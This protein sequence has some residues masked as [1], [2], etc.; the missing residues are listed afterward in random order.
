MLGVL[1]PSQHETHDA[2]THRRWSLDV[3]PRRKRAGGD[4]NLAE[5][6]ECKVDVGFGTFRAIPHQKRWHA[7]KALPSSWDAP[8][9]AWAMSW[10]TRLFRLDPPSTD[11]PRRDLPFR[12]V[13]FPFI[14]F[15]LPGLNRSVSRLFGFRCDG[16]IELRFRHGTN[17]RPTDTGS[18]S[19]PLLPIP[20]EDGTL[21][22]RLDRGMDVHVDGTGGAHA[23]RGR[24]GR[25]PSS[26]GKGTAVQVGEELQALAKVPTRQVRRRETRRAPRIE[27]Y[28]LESRRRKQG[29]LADE[30]AGARTKRRRSP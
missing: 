20:S 3:P 25:R 6:A 7:W 17:R 27:S 4:P 10:P 23:V 28:V 21:R 30:S 16:P 26:P 13:V 22:R 11:D 18:T 1:C 19:P 29:M 24:E 8:D 15:L 14:P 2:Y 9:V 5:D 12:S